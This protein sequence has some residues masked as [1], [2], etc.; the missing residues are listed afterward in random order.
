MIRSSV[1]ILTLATVL[2]LLPQSTASGQG[3]AGN[4]GGGGPAGTRGDNPP[5]DHGALKR[6]CLKRTSQADGAIRDHIGAVDGH[7]A[8]IL[9]DVA[10]RTREFDRIRTLTLVGETR[11]EGI[12]TFLPPFAAPV[13]AAGPPLLPDLRD[14]NGYARG[15][16]LELTRLHAQAV[17]HRIAVDNANRDME[18]LRLT[19][20]RFKELFEN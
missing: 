13:S 20:V 5:I 15:E 14:C 8:A 11:G 12:A 9:D 18:N 4:G 7:R 2:V 19:Y 17:D 3:N 10:Q 1:T 16:I 6:D